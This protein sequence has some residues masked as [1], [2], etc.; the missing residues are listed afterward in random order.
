MQARRVAG[1]SGDVIRHHHSVV[2][3][4]FVDAHRLEH[5]HVPVV[6]QRLVKVEKTSANVAEM[7]IE[8]LTATAEVIDWPRPSSIRGRIFACSYLT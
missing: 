5:I 2:A 8:D 4:L 6:N 3:D 1:D 7:E